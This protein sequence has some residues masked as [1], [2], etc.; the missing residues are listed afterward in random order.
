[1]NGKNIAVIRKKRG[2]SQEEL[3]Q[4]LSINTATL[5]RWENGHFEPKA[6]MI[7][8]LCNILNCSEFELLND[9]KS[10]NWELKLVIKKKGNESMN[11]VNLTGDTSSA[12]LEMSDDGMGIT[13]SA[14]YELWEDDAKFENLIEQLRKKRNIGLKTR[15]EDW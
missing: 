4:A 1:M 10:Q 7:K 3:A 13:L 2:I 12:T 8:E 9:A 6:S 15:K 5:S 14:S 11:I